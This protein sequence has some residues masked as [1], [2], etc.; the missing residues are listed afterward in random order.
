MKLAVVVKPT[1]K[2]E[3][4]KA[5]FESVQEIITKFGGNIEKVDDG[6][7]VN[8]LT[9]LKNLMKVFITL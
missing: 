5:E 7:N 9:K 2:E 1:L 3:A 6:A 8:L 4:L